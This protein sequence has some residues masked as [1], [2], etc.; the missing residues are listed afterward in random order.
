LQGKV[1]TAIVSVGN[2]QENV[3]EWWNN[4]TPAEQKN[5]VNKA[6]YETANRALDAAGNLLN[7][8][9]ESLNDGESATGTIL[10]REKIE[11]CLELYRRC[12]ISIE[13]T[14]D[15]QGGNWIPG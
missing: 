1:D 13:Q 5:P 6:K 15:D 14:L 11:R 8:L 2:K 4:L 9:D 3:D 7:S 12:P 10:T